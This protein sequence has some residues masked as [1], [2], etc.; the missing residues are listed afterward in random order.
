MFRVVI[1]GSRVFD[2]YELLAHKMDYFLSETRQPVTVLCGLAEGAD[3]LGLR[4]A[5]DRKFNVEYYPADWQRFGRSAGMRR[6][7][8]MAENADALVAFWDG[9]SRG[10][11]NMITVAKTKGLKVRVVRYDLEPQLVKDSYA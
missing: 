11:L 3:K 2:N 5:R 9:K 4:Y 10:T 1:A 6:N 8:E 7:A